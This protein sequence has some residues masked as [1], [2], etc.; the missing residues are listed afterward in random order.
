MRESDL[1]LLV[2]AARKA[3]TIA[4][5]YFGQSP[6][7]TNKPGGAGPVT[8]ADLAVDLITAGCPRNHKTAPP[9]CPRRASS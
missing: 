6:Q 2:A 8:E 9:A 3:G 5:G 4:T 7:V 1:T